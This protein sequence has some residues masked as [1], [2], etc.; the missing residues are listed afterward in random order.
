MVFDHE[1]H[2]RLALE[3]IQV[4]SFKGNSLELACGF[5]KAVLSAEIKKE[6]P[7]A[8]AKDMPGPGASDPPPAPGTQA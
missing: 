5:K 4:S 1:E 3:L 6:A 8:P 7:A 2:R